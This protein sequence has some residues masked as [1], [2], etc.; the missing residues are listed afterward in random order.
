M[1][2]GYVSSLGCCQRSYLLDSCAAGQFDISNAGMQFTELVPW[3]ET[4]A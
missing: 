2:V 1:P 4:L 3:I